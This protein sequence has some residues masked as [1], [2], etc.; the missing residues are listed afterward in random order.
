M[1]LF[2]IVNSGYRLN[3]WKGNCKDKPKAAQREDVA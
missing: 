1:I 2:K 3:E